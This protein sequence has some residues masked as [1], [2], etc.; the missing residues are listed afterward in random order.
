MATEL[1]EAQLITKVDDL[2]TLIDAAFSA[3]STYSYRI[4]DIQVSKSE[5]IKDLKHQRDY[6][7]AELRRVQMA[8]EPLFIGADEEV[9]PFGEVLGEEVDE[10]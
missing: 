7:L 2:N 6:Y 8:G 4:G 3:G 10:D 1:T 5:Y 9:S